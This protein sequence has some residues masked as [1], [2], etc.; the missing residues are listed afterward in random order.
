MLV[1]VRKDHA[2]RE[3]S[4]EVLGFETNISST[5]V[6]RILHKHNLSNVK[7]TRKPG[8]NE[9]QKAARL[10]FTLDH[11]HWKLEDWMRVIW[12]D[13]TS[14][15]LG[16]RR[17]AIR[18]WRDPHEVYGKTTIRNRFKGFSEFIWWSCFTY[19]DKGPWHIW[20]KEI[21]QERKVADKDLE[22]LNAALEPLMRARWEISIGV[23]RLD[24]RGQSKGKKPQW[25]WNK[26][27]RKLVRDSTGG[28]D[29][30]RYGKLIVHL[31][32]IPFLRQCELSRAAQGLFNSMIVQENN[33]APYAH[34][35]TR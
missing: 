12:T 16:Q 35:N 23:R 14:V 32:I 27:N 31:K 8:L 24:L 19:H 2:G 28:I 7:P 15:I 30:Y 10:R 3:K 25:R 21:A 26:T 6:L 13:E 22:E 9:A 20:R 5:S 34:T 4:S 18:L 29:W 17:G 1:I 33:A 11:R